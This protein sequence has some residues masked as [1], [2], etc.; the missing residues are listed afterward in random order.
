M[1]YVVQI[2]TSIPNKISFGDAFPSEML[3]LHNKYNSYIGNGLIST[4]FSDPSDTETSRTMTLT[5]TDQ[6]HVPSIINDVA[7]MTEYSH[8]TDYMTQNNLTD[9]I[10]TTTTP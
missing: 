2:K 7:S 1:A 3:A 8:R 9:T 6:S 10:L 5:F 4:S